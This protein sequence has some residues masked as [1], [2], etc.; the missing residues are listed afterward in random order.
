MANTTEPRASVDLVRGIIEWPGL[1]NIAFELSAVRRDA[2]L[3]GLDNMTLMM[4]WLPDVE[5]YEQRDAVARPWIYDPNP[6]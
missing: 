6:A 5:Q 4:R 1:G 3:Q 2:L